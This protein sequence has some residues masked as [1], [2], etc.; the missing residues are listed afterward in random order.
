M[1]TA[2]VL[3]ETLSLLWKLVEEAG[4]DGT[5]G[6]FLRMAEWISTE[7]VSGLCWWYRKYVPA[8]MVLEELEREPPEA[9]KGLRADPPAS[10]AVGVAKEEQVTDASG[11]AVDWPTPDFK[12]IRTIVCGISGTRTI[13]TS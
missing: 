8:D 5:L 3:D 11:F 12:T 1:R 13:G 9:K 10:A 2:A 4:P 7:S 6:L